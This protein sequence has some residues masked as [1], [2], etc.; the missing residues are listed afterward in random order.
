MT[1]R[2]DCINTFKVLVK[3]Q[4]DTIW[5]DNDHYPP[6]DCNYATK[7]AD[8]ISRILV[9]SGF[10]LYYMGT[11]D[12]KTHEYTYFHRDFDKKLFL[13]TNNERNISWIIEGSNKH[14]NN[15][16]MICYLMRRIFPKL[17]TNSALLSINSTV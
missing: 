6:C 9:Q 11:V 13:I 15:T 1:V 5:L 2:Q 7:L 12:Q 4:G 14:H 3:L 16:T 8:S 10:N 17:K